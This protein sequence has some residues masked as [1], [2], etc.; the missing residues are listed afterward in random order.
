MGPHGTRIRRPGIK[1]AKSELSHIDNRGIKTIISKW[2]SKWYGSH[3][4]SDGKK[5]KEEFTKGLKEVE[6]G[7]DENGRLVYRVLQ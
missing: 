3:L 7:Y 2:P 5:L 6:K 1:V 4:F